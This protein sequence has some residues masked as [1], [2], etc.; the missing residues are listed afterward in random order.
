MSSNTAVEKED[1]DADNI[2]VA[3]LAGDT[4][5]ISVNITDDG[6]GEHDESFVVVITGRD[7]GVGIT[8]LTVTI[9][10]NDG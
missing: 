5:S 6:T 4:V 8:V 2:T 1:F 9:I 10:D 7:V 3:V